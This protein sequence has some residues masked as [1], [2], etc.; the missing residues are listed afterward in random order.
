MITVP[1]L[2][3]GIIHSPCALGDICRA[4]IAHI[5]VAHLPFRLRHLRNLKAGIDSLIAHLIVLGSRD[6]L[7]FGWAEKAFIHGAP[8][9]GIGI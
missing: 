1:P 3:D 4:P 8:P 2:C 5:Q 9:R 6:A 7:A